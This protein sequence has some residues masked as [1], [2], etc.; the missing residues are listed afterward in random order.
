MAEHTS[1]L[2]LRGS[3]VKEGPEAITLKI[4]HSLF[5]IQRSYVENL[6]EGEEA[7]DGKVVEVK[8]FANALMI[9]R[10][11]APASTLVM[12]IP[13]LCNC[14]CVCDCPSQCSACACVCD[15]SGSREGS[16]ESSSFRSRLR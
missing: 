1:G 13:I 15:C 11:L 7:E 10:V 8:I 2:T 3:M 6:R 16:R 9:Q 12:S 4:G 14:A 5:E